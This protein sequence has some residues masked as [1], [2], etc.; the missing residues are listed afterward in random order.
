MMQ[1]ER[2]PFLTLIFID[3]YSRGEGGGAV[4]GS[5]GKAVLPRLSN[6][7]PELFMTKIFHFATLFKSRD[8]IS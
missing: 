8:L 6:P 5:L 4:N 2:P 1:F 3:H 7:D